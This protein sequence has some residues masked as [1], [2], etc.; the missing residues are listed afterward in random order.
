MLASY[1]A[2]VA[3]PN[4]ARFCGVLPFA[5]GCNLQRVAR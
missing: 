5:L 2:A 1:G 3:G 4:Y